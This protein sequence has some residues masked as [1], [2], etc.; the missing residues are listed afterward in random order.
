MRKKLFTVS[1]SIAAILF[2]FATNQ[3]IY[4]CSPSKGVDHDTIVPPPPP[5]PPPPPVPVISRVDL[6]MSDNSF[7]GSWRFTYDAQKRVIQIADNASQGVT[8]DTVFYIFSYSGTNTKPSSMR[9]RQVNGM[10]PSGAPE[11]TL[12]YTYD[13][14][15]NL[16]SDRMLRVEQH[17][18]VFR[19]LRVRNYVYNGNQTIVDWY[20]I[21]NGESQLSLY[22]TDTLIKSNGNI[23]KWSVRVPQAHLL[24]NGGIGGFLVQIS[25][26]SFMSVRNPLSTLNITGLPFMW[27]RK[28]GEVEIMGNDTYT[29]YWN[30]SLFPRCF[31]L[32]SDYLPQG[33]VMSNY[34]LDGTF[35][36]TNFLSLGISGQ[37]VNEYP[38]VYKVAPTSGGVMGYG[39]EYRFVYQ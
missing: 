16:I 36:T 11:D 26:P 39:Q 38:T 21:N 5:P 14:A 9:I 29:A 4:S 20:S 31:D 35:M 32:T 2:I 3:V 22:R 1:A 10:F 27:F 7:M 12:F 24:G 25:N 18:P 23:S 28:R 6:Y 30:S 37:I 13:A 8:S 34:M 19:R 33:V 17:N 15:N